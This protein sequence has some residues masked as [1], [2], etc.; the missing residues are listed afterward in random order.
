MGSLLSQAAFDLER[1]SATARLDAELLLSFIA[2]ASRGALLAFPERELDAGLTESFAAAIQRRARGEPLAYITGRR[3]FYSLEL[4]VTPDVLVPR[5]DTE[6]LVDAVLHH[7]DAAPRSTVLDVGTGSGAIALAVK[8]Q[9][10]GVRVT[11]VDCDAAALRIAAANAS[12]LGLDVRCLEPNW[13]SAA[14]GERF[15]LIV[16]NP[17]YVRSDD[18][19]FAG[20]LRFEPRL[21]L[22]G[23]RDGLEAYRAIFAR[24]GQH[25]EPAGLLLV[26]HGYDQR[27]SVLELGVENGFAPVALLDDLSGVPRV[28]VLEAPRT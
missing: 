13:F 3:E 2:G 1:V 8:Q 6:T 12:R 7:L 20:S 11:A 24:A 26:E 4:H 15:D 28:A 17:P 19:H 27:A 5:A 25:L 9:R 14:V 22:D 10:P 21:A 18:P 23:G 16:S